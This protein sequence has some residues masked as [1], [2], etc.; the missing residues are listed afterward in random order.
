VSARTSARPQTAWETIIPVDL[1]SVFTGYGPLPAVTGTSEQTGDWNSVGET[2]RIDL[3]DGSHTGEE[4]LIADQPNHFGYRVGPF[5]GPIGKL[6]SHADGRFWFYAAESGTVVRWS[7]TW[8]P[9]RGAYA[10][11]WPV[12]RLW[13]AYAKRLIVDLAALA[14]A[15]EPA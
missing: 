14:D 5:S 3:S 13:K 15:S 10:I 4:I 8:V 6:V 9:R 1:T 12:T 7:Y 11:V 2:R